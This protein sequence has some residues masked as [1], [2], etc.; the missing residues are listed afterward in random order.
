MQFTELCRWAPEGSENYALDVRASP[1]DLC[2]NS[3]AKESAE[4]YCRR[5]RC[6]LLNGWAV[7]LV[8]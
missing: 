4:Q 6:I 8:H 3:M 7:E 2:Y 1:L 5:L